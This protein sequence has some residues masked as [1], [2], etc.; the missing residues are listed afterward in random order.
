MWNLEDKYLPLW[1]F[2]LLFCNEF[3]PNPLQNAAADVVQPLPPYDFSQIS[4]WRT[5]GSASPLVHLGQYSISTYKLLSGV[6]GGLLPSWI[7]KRWNLG[8][9]WCKVHALLP[10]YSPF[11]PWEE[12]IMPE[13]SCLNLQ[14]KLYNLSCNL[15]RWYLELSGTVQ[16]EL[17]SWHSK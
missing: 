11:I 4:H 10:I 15:N 8:P 5:G 6:S 1:F 9:S 14:S 16:N 17:Q 12:Y 2:S 7:W 3:N 13:A